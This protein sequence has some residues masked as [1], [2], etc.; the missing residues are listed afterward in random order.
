[1]SLVIFD[2]DGVLID[3]ERPT[4][5][6]YKEVLAEE[7]G[8][9][10]TDEDFE[11]KKGKKSDDFFRSVLSPEQLASVNISA[12]I[13]RKRRD[14][15]DHP[16]QYI[17]KYQGSDG[18][19]AALHQEGFALALGS[20]NERSMIDATLQRFKWNRFFSFTTSIQDVTR[21][22]PDPEIFLTC[23]EKLSFNPSE[24]IVIEDSPDGIQAATAAGIKTIAIASSFSPDYLNSAHRIVQTL[25]DITIDSISTLLNS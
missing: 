3:S 8:I 17:T 5:L 9:V 10:L 14:F 4:F 24:A 12:L 1:M 16:D 7:Y 23:L 20:Q 21:K 18:I 19:L 25:Q 22:K 13:Q 6:Y 11:H 2:F 15:I